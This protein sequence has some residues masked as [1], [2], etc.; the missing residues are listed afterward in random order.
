MES[1]LP[2]VF[3]GES[4]NHSNK[5]SKLGFSI[6]C[7]QGDLPL[8]RGCLSSIR[9]FAPD[10]PICLIADGNFCT[11][12]FERNYGVQVIRKEDVKIAGLRNHS[13][14]MGLT[15]MIAFWEA[16]FDTIFHIDADAVLWGDPRKNLPE[17]NWD[18]VYN[19]PHE[20]ITDFIQK[21]QYFDPSRIFDHI[22]SF[23]WEGNP[24]FQAG[25]VCIKR[26]VLDLDEYLRMLEGQRK[27]PDIF[28]NGDQGMLNILV[29]RALHSGKLKTTSAHLQSVIPVLENED[30]EKRFQIIEGFPVVEQATILHWAGPKPWR[31]NK[32]IFRKPMDFFRARGFRECGLSKMIPVEIAMAMEEFRLREWPKGVSDFKIFLKTNIRQFSKRM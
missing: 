18:V 3:T 22:N 6:S 10:A 12:S 13:F 19:E 24:Y 17:G 27:H 20:E 23:P 8:L 28:I 26:N 29:F 25:V 16:P 15:K 11:R 2:C 14:G 7:Y 9:Y 31:E 5:V 30:L 4:F 1:L 32:E 21:T